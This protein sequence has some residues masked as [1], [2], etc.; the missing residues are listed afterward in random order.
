M[1]CQ[2]INCNNNIKYGDFCYKHRKYYLINKDETINKSRF[3][4]NIKDYTIKNLRKSINYHVY[5]K[6]KKE[7]YSLYISIMN[8]RNEYKNIIK[9]QSIVR[10]YIV[11]KQLLR[12]YGYFNREISKNDEDFYFMTDKKDIPNIY[13]FSYKDD[14]N[15]IWCFDIRSFKKLIEYK[16][17][18]PYTREIIH[19]D[20]IIKANKIINNLKKRNINIEIDKLILK[21]KK[22]IVKQKCVDL[23]SNISEQGYFCNIEW[24]LSLSTINL[25]KLYKNLEDI[26]NYR[27]YLTND[28]KSRIAPPNGIVYNISIRE[29]YNMNNKYDIIDLILNE[30]NKFNNA[31]ENSDKILGYMY[32]LIGLSEISEECLQSNP[33]INFALN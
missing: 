1:N 6:N 2:C 14:N 32:F 19:D 31:I 11:Q 29:V 16:N 26:W 12:G 28:V 21:D 4:W 25:K 33:L 22:D 30:T 10:R 13:Y 5:N 27:A 7:I 15:N 20:I 18:N 3:T 24:I 17:E 9:C 8:D 23:V